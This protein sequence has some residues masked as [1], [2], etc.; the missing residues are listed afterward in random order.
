MVGERVES[1]AYTA[2]VPFSRLLEFSYWFITWLI[3]GSG[4]RRS[5][6]SNTVVVVILRNLA[7][8]MGGIGRIGTDVDG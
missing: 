8:T 3:A 7:G 2:L 6:H 4:R 1:W 5:R